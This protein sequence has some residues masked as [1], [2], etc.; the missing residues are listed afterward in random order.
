MVTVRLALVSDGRTGRGPALVQ[1]FE[2]KY[3]VGRKLV[4]TLRAKAAGI[5][6]WSPHDL[7]HRRISLLHLRGMPW[8][9]IG[10]F[11]GQRDLSVTADT[12]THAMVD[13]TE[14]DYSELLG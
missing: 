5:P 2:L 3:L 8:A 10:E 11:V 12:Y 1:P 14:I 4:P 7:R 9:R 13:E 6:L